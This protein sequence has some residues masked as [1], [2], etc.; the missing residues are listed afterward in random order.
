M[1]NTRNPK[2]KL[3][4]II[5]AAGMGMRLSMGPKALLEL[6]G[7]ALVRIVAEK[8]FETVETVLVGFTP[9]Y[10]DRF[11]TALKSLPVI[12][13]PGGK[14]RQQTIL[15]L[16]EQCEGNADAI[17]VDANRPLVPASTLASVAEDLLHHRASVNAVELNCP[18]CL[19]NARG[20]VT[21][22]FSYQEAIMAGGV[23]GARLPL[24]RA[25]LRKAEA[26]GENRLSLVA[27]LLAH[28][29]TPH[30]V[31]SP[32]ECLKVTDAGD[33]SHVQHLWAQG[34]R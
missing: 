26:S 16:L 30:M 8:M 12:L 29:V 10:Q 14:T 21:R 4:G 7:I 17:V 15:K 3:Y 18:V 32:P 2:R 34:V 6:G 13:I 27:A 19:F 22:Q 20:K 11:A 5:P 28:G 33:W 31:R 24:L 1:T 25:A 9:G 23:V